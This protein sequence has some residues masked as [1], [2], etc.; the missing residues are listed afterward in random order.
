MVLRINYNVTAVNSHRNLL[1]I[2]R[3]LGATLNRLSSGL[4]VQ[5][6]SDDPAALILANN[7]RY[8][9]RA[10]EQSINNVE[11]GLNFIGTA[12]GAMDEMSTILTR[13]RTL[14]IGATSA[15]TVD[16]NSLRAMQRDMDAAI[17]SFGRIATDTRYGSVSLL[18]G[19]LAGNRI[20]AASEGRIAAVR[21]DHSLIAGGIQAGSALSITSAGI[22]VDRSRIT[23]PFGAGTAAST[24]LSTALGPGVVGQVVAITGP[25]GVRNVTVD[26]SMTIEGFIAAAN[27][28]GSQIGV[29][30]GYDSVTGMM[31]LQNES[32]GN[33]ALSIASGN[34][35]LDG[36]TSTTTAGTNQQ[37]TLTYTDAA[38]VS[39]PGI[40]LSQVATA[41]G[42]LA[43][44][45][46]AGDSAGPNYA[47][48]AP[49]AFTIVLDDTSEGQASFALAAGGYGATRASDVDIHSGALEDQRIAIDIPD[50]RIAVLGRTA[51]LAA[52]GFAALDDLMARNG[53][54]AYSGALVNG[55]TATAL[56][57]VDAAIRELL[58][59]RAQAGAIAGNAL[60][61]TAASLRA[62]RQSLLQSESQLRDV[63]FAEE[64]AEYAKQNVLLQAATAMLAQ[65]N[66]VP[67]TVLQLL[68]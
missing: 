41:D 32:F 67:Q 5:K 40:T 11:E 27:A 55:D 59:A 43:F 52:G 36:A 18:A 61:T 15:A 29:T 42:G 50:L 38:G 49:G 53:P 1:R 6:A 64:S 63:D 13:I 66:Q 47:L 54:P 16:G 62:S 33:L 14:V 17:E 48:Y 20:D 39:H 9:A 68:R 25:G 3:D 7:L 57:V 21:A 24:L 35:L 30:A 56:S 22:T 37:L 19:G 2:D 4:Q 28:V 31:R 60:E 45:N 8:N 44:T 10:V 34:G 46:A 65:A 12:E 58:D 23:Q 26:S 51:G